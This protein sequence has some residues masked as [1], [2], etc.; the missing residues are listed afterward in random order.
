MQDRKNW[1]AVI[2]LLHGVGSRTNIT[3]WLLSFSYLLKQVSLLLWLC[4]C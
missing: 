1:T 3:V 2:G 4:S